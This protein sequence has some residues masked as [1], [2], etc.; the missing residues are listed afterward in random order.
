MSVSIVGVERIERSGVRRL[1]ALRRELA[2]LSALSVR[3]PKV[4]GRPVYGLLLQRPVVS[5]DGAAS[6]SRGRS[7]RPRSADNSVLYKVLQEH[8]ESF[9]AA[10]DSAD[11]RTRLPG[12]VR[13]ELRGHLSCGILSHGFA[14]FKCGGCDFDR[15]VP[16]SCKGRGICP[17]CGGKRM[18]RL[19]AELTD[20][21]V[22]WVPVRQFVL[23]VPHHHSYDLQ[24][25]FE[26]CIAVLLRVGPMPGVCARLR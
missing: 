26:L 17:S 10:A 4:S 1:S 23:S 7:Y 2:T 13:K 9:L 21:V 11:D 15:W 14:R 8:P 22:P 6:L 3:K 12:F 16:F 20:R 19:A 5:S 24:A 18:T 25:S